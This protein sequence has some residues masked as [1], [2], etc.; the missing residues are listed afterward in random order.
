MTCSQADGDCPIIAGAERRIAV[1]FDDPKISDGSPEQS[2][3]YAERSG[4]IGAEMFYVFSKIN[5]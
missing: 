3:V 1:T 2:E 4:Q 5:P